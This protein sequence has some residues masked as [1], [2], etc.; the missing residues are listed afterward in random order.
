MIRSILSLGILSVLAGAAVMVKAAEVPTLATVTGTCERLVIAGQDV[1]GQCTGSLLNTSYAT[2]RV[3]FYFVTGDGGALTFTGLGSAQ[4]KL[5]PDTAVQP[6]DGVIFGFKG[7][8]D[9]VK[10]VGMC[11]F[12]NPVAQPGSVSCSAETP[13]GAF[14]AE[15]VTDGKPPEIVKP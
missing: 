3:G 14:A 13:G 7:Q 10:A 2:G 11:R 4:V 6:V 5:D 1:T 8:Y 12:T 15:F 9:R